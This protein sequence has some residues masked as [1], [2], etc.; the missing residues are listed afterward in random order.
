VFP[1]VELYPLGG[2]ATSRATLHQQAISGATTRGLWD[3]LGVTRYGNAPESHTPLL[4]P[5]AVVAGAVL[6]GTSRVGETSAIE[7]TLPTVMFHPLTL[8]RMD[9]INLTELPQLLVFVDQGQFGP[10][11]RAAPPVATPVEGGGM[12]VVGSDVVAV[13]G[14]RIGSPARR[15][16]RALISVSRAGLSSQ[17]EMDVV[18]FYT[19]RLA[20]TDG[21]SS[22]D[23]YPSFF[24]A[25]GGRATLATM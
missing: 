8:Y 9:L 2:W 14:H 13:D 1:G 6:E 21:V 15:L 16:R 19:V 24:E 10:T 23:G 5:G 17:A 11:D 25:T 3:Q 18:K 20:A 4:S 22:W 12:T 7:R